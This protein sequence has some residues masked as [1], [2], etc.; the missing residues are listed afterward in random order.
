MTLLLTRAQMK[1]EFQRLHAST[2]TLLA[3]YK[4]VCDGSIGDWDDDVAAALKDWDL[5]GA[6]LLPLLFKDKTVCCRC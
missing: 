6:M 3:D 4:K 2:K 1:A 5:L